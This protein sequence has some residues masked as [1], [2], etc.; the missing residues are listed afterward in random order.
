MV[1]EINWNDIKDKNKQFWLENPWKY[2]K[3]NK[4]R[5][6]NIINTGKIMIKEIKRIDTKDKSKQ[7]WSQN[8]RKHEKHNK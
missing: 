2:E 5:T 8:P 7:L 3:Y 4:Q 6:K 1:K